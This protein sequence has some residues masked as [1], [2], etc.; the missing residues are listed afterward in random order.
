MGEPLPGGWLLRMTMTGKDFNRKRAG[1][2]CGR[3]RFVAFVFDIVVDVLHIGNEGRNE[4]EVR[5][6][7]D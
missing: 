1:L 2:R 3:L 5:S 4:G 6:T 7:A